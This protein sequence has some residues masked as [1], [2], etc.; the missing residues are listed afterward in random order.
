MGDGKT[1]VLR[2]GKVDAYRF[3]TF[4]LEPTKDNFEDFFQKVVDPIWIDQSTDPEALA[5]RSANQDEN[6]PK[7]WR[8][9]HRVTFV[10]RILKQVEDTSA[11]PNTNDDYN[12]AMGNAG[13]ESQYELMKKLDPFVSDKTESH[14]VFAAA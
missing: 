12:Q 10:S 2:P 6:K 7:C 5:L 8:I 1:P 13:V 3:M 11:E 14:E 4:Y 9:M